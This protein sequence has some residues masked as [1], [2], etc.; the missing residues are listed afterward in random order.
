[1]SAVSGP[2]SDSR[3]FPTRPIVGVG[4]VVID[5][6]RVLLVRRV[7]E[8]LKD[9][10]SL[11]GGAVELG[12]TLAAAIAREVR[13]E[14]GLEVEVGPIVDV[15]D[16]LRIDPD[17]RPRF[18]YVLIDFICRPKGGVLASGSDAADV[19]WATLS[20]LTDYA[21]ADSAV[22]VI[23]KAIDRVK[24]GPWIPREAHRSPE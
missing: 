23:V 10:W 22:T 13:E 5:G 11:P 15:L 16:R 1:M 2:P 7:N 4:A 3:E 8:P 6:D 9:E 21:V 24:S 20:E 18:H 14:T 19:A 12:E 17:G